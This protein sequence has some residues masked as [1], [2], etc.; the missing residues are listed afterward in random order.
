MEPQHIQA[1]PAVMSEYHLS[2]SDYQIVS[3]LKHDKVWL[4]RDKKYGRM[5]VVKRMEQYRT[6]FPI[7]LHQK[8]YES[9]LRVPP[10]L[11][12]KD[13]EVYVRKNDRYF[14]VNEFVHSLKR[15][16]I[17]SRIEALAAFHKTARFESLRGIDE[18]LEEIELENFMKDYSLKI[19]DIIQWVDMVETPALKEE[20]VEM[21]RMGLKV[22]HHIQQ[23][24]HVEDYLLTMKEKHMICHADFN[25]NNAFLTKEGNVLLMD[26]DF[27]HF[28]P[29][30]EDFRFLMMSF[31]RKE[32]QDMEDLLS[33]LFTI[34]FKCL[35]E[36]KSYKEFYLFD[37]M[38]PHDFHKQLTSILKS[39]NK[40]S[41]EANKE[42]IIFLASRE[43]AKYRF[44]LRGELK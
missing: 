36:D 31:M 43:K 1:L 34:Y 40:D 16:T 42:R 11:M 29:P 37:S 30:I 21:T 9:G 7:L 44:L 39:E 17:E 6:V 23:N 19:K 24:L 8:L 33:S 27:A 13:G 26:F 2:E 28:G 41:L 3:E 32:N 5:L 35:E 12:T 20:L 10:V 38:F 15:I 14:Y 18:S 25:T 22:F 4:V